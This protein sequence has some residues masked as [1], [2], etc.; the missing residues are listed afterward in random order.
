MGKNKNWP[1]LVCLLWIGCGISSGHVLAQDARSR[2]VRI[3]ESQLSVREASGNNDG[4]QVQAFL[5][6]T[7]LKGNYPWCAAFL[8]WTFIQADIKAPR[9]AYSPDWFRTNVVYRQHKPTI[10]P[11][12]SQPAQVFGLYFESKKRV[13]HVGMIVSETRLSYATIEGNTNAQGSREG[14]GVYRKIRNK[15]TIYIISDY[16]P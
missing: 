13:A 8:S 1:F 6:T 4:A 12:K 14:D 9:S 2:V 16:I 15:R 11:F 10:T 5:A 7:G 3:A